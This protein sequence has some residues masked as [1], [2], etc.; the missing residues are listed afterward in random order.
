MT[1]DLTQKKLAMLE[2]DMRVL[3]VRLDRLE[4]LQGTGLS[5]GQAL[6]ALDRYDAQEEA[7]NAIQRRIDTL[8]RMV[9]AYAKLSDDECL[10]PSVEVIELKQTSDA[11]KF[12]SRCT[13]CHKVIERWTESGAAQTL[14]DKALVG[15]REDLDDMRCES[16]GV[17]P[18]EVHEDDC[19]AMLEGAETGDNLYAGLGRW[20]DNDG[21][22]HDVDCAMSKTGG[23]SPCTCSQKQKPEPASREAVDIFNKY[24]AGGAPK[25]RKRTWRTLW[26]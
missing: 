9:K 16:C 2:A 19:E 15:V 23:K 3:L 21:R 1:D 4:S 14:A 5:V 17:L 11:R 24:W 7:D 25:R 13:S 26:M 12:E 22:V 18:G 20:R 8:E 10:H 6:T